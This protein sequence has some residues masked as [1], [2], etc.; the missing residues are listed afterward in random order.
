MTGAASKIKQW[1]RLEPRLEPRCQLSVLMVCMGNICRSP[2][3]EGALRAR[4]KREGLDEWVK[5]DSA[6]IYG[7]H[8]GARP[9]ARAVAHAAQRGIDI[10]R[11]RAREVAPADFERFDLLLAMDSDNLSNLRHHCPEDL[12][13]RLGLLLAMDANNLDNLRQRCPPGLQRKLR[14]L[15]SFAAAGPGAAGG[16][17]LPDPYYGP[18]AGFEHVLDRIEA[19]MSGLVAELRR[20]LAALPT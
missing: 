4:L 7:G 12:Q 16:E 20:R 3:A 5:V 11:L 15:L 8:K 19:S 14:L 6:G 13:G 18:P 17:E 1:L 10:S 9:D 2:T